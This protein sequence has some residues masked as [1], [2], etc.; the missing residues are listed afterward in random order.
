MDFVL[1]QRARFLEGETRAAAEQLR[2][3]AIADIAEEVGLEPAIREE[4]RIDLGIVEAAHGTD[5]EPE[6]ARRNDEI[7]A[8]QGAVAHRGGGGDDFLARPAEPA[9][10]RLV[11]R[12]R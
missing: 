2:A 3:V 4:G 8:L 5:I 12:K 1:R 10:R 6:R 11:V 9:R 7:G